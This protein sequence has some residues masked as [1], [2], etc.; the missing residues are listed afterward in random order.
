[1]L[2]CFFARRLVGIGENEDLLLLLPFDCEACSFFLLNLLLVPLTGSF[3][4]D[5][6]QTRGTS[7]GA[8]VCS[9]SERFELFLKAGDPLLT[10]GILA[11]VYRLG[12]AFRGR[13]R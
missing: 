13:L 2:W 6:L 1:M 9:S 11:S 10:L 7:F 12:G 4:L 3:E 5:S 8:A